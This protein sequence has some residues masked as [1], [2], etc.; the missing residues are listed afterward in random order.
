MQ[1]SDGGD[2]RPLIR[3]NKWHIFCLRFSR[4]IW[5]GDRVG[6]A[7]PLRCVRPWITEICQ[8]HADGYL[9]LTVV[10]DWRFSQNIGILQ[11][12]LIKSRHSIPLKCCKNSHV[13]RWSSIV[14]LS[15][16]QLLLWYLVFI[17]TTRKVYYS[18]EHPTITWELNDTAV[19]SNC[20]D[21]LTSGDGQIS[22]CWFT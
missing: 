3:M 17:V 11:C 16:D 13:W 14:Y 6:V 10:S 2:F 7:L 12:L 1:K 20:T 19:G 18:A 5:K 9:R 22:A 21:Y 8:G 15:Y 4:L